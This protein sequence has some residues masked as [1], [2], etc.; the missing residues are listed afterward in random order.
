MGGF[1]SPPPPRLSPH[2]EGALV[3]FPE[4][5]GLLVRALDFGLILLNRLSVLFQGGLSTKH[6]A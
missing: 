3:L 4:F 1:F 5:L 2:L 6:I